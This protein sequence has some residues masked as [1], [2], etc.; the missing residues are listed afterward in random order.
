MDHR[1]LS[2][3]GF[4]YICLEKHAL[5]RQ[6]RVGGV[7]GGLLRPPLYGIAAMTTLATDGKMLVNA[8][9]HSAIVSGL[10]AGYA[11]LGKMVIGGSPPKLDLTPRDDLCRVKVAL[12]LAA[13]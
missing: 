3:W 11:R 13:G 1:G 5:A 7:G 12:A 2:S 10:A 8:L 9:Y 4:T 6:S